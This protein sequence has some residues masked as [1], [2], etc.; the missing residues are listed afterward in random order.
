[1]NKFEQSVGV[2]V[3]C[4]KRRNDCHELKELLV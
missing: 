3:D 2:V 4:G 1:M